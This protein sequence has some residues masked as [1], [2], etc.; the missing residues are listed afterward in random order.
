MLNL[1]QLEILRAVVQYRTTVGA[2]EQLGM[3]QP[4]ISNTIR[5]IETVL[6]FPLFERQS[7]RLIPTEEAL[8]LLEE[9]EPLFLL[10]DAVNQRAGDLRAGRIGRV[11]IASTAEISEA[12][13]P[14][15][16]ADYARQY[17][18]IQISLETRPLDTVLQVIENGLADVAFVISAYDH[19]A[20]D[21]DLVAVLRAV[22]ICPDDHPLAQLESVT[23]R[24]LDGHPL[25]GPRTANRVGMMIAEGF[26]EA[27][28]D[29]RPSI[30]TRFMNA[31]AR[32]VGEGWGIA[33]VDELSAHTALRPG[34]TVR[35]FHLNLRFNLVAAT[36]KTKTP[37]RQCKRI[38]K[39]F[40]DRVKTQLAEMHAAATQP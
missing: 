6:G 4:S 17:P 16:I 22:C 39:A 34:L 26:N 18:Q 12:V 40:S 36:L 31:A 25:I 28:R 19:Q 8:I 1:R 35:P 14:R 9:S 3:S 7:N 13:L 10:R 38:I 30:E 20:L 21:F 15:V 11:R 37:S 29:Y 2:A 23:P 33:V 27:G 32:I 24:D 5:H